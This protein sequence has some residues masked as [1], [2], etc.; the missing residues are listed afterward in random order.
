MVFCVHDEQ[1]PFLEQYGS[2][3]AAAGHQ[4][5]FGYPL[6]ECYHV[7][8]S[9]RPTLPSEHEFVITLRQDV[10]KFSSSRRQVAG[11]CV[12]QDEQMCGGE[13][14]TRWLIG[15]LSLFMRTN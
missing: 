5:E 14:W 12:D 13:Y 8:A 10:V 2:R 3:Q 9:I 11:V 7:S 6:A 1:S 15:F 4:P